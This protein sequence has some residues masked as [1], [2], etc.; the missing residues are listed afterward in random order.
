[1]LS[2]TEEVFTF[3]LNIAELMTSRLEIWLARTS[4]ATSITRTMH[5]L[6]VSLQHTLL[7]SLQ[8]TL[9]VSWHTL[10]V[11]LHFCESGITI[12][13][14][15]ILYTSWASRGAVFVPLN[16]LKM[17]WEFLRFLE[18]LIVFYPQNNQ[19]AHP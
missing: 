13:S 19:I 5:T 1:M 3:L 6:L 11:S 2:S 10:L 12:L 9:L 14:L 18:S 15:H 17:F 8:H 16:F 7:V 4:L